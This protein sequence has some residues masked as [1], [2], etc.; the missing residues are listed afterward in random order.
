MV[1]IKVITE[2]IQELKDQIREEAEKSKKFR[3][4]LMTFDPE[5]NIRQSALL[6]HAM[7]HPSEVFSIKAH[8]TTNHISYQTA[9]TDLLELA[10]KGYLKQIKKGKTFYFISADN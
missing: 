1:N 9:R 10:D 5:L 6:F 8:Q 7:K 4:G 3:Q 2:A